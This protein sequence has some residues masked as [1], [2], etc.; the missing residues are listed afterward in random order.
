[1]DVKKPHSLSLYVPA[2][3]MDLCGLYMALTLLWR[4]FKPSWVPIL[5]TMALYPLSFLSQSLTGRSRGAARQTQGLTLTLG[6]LGFSVVALLAIRQVLSGG[7]GLTGPGLF[8]IG[9]QVVF[10]GLSWWLAGTLFQEEIEHRYFAFRFQV[11]FLFILFLGGIEGTPFVPIILFFV[12]AGAA[13]ALA[14]WQDSLAKGRILLRPLHPG[15]LALSLVGLVF[16]GLLIVFILSP[17][18]ARSIWQGLEGLGRTIL[19]LFSYLPPPQKAK[20]TDLHFS[21]TWRPKAPPQEGVAVRTIRPA[22]GG[23]MEV[24]S[25]VLW[26]VLIGILIGVAAAMFLMMR[27]RRADRSTP[28]G[29]AVEVEKIRLSVKILQGLASMIKRLQRWA[30]RFWL[31]LL[32]RMTRLARPPEDE[33]TKSVR[34]LYRSL[35][36]WAARRGVPRTL[37]DT[38]LEY[39][40]QLC[41]RF[42]EGAQE[43][44]VVTKAYIQ[45]RYSLG[46]QEGADFMV[47]RLAWQK[48]RSLK[49]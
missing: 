26:A 38:P 18:V 24:P 48:I 16:S 1:M 2:M 42:P 20:A 17:E 6:A 3:G 49:K 12:L 40:R 22:E 13:L 25:L 29:P 45:A 33:S 4:S 10:C 39:L 47:I 43:L 23:T 28:R 31:S 34:E 7:S 5:L 41:Q 8:W 44:T 46:Q 37:S 21:C 36:R 11:G 19:L 15:L 30:K 14:R 35:L 27:K 9:L 32:G